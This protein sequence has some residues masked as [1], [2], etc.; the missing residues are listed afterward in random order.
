MPPAETRPQIACIALGSNLGDRRAAIRAAVA[1]I[2][3][4]HGTSI[5]A[6]SAPVETAPVGPPGQR[7]YLNAAASIET[8]LSPRDLLDALLRIEHDLGR[9]RR[10]RWGPRTIDLDLILFGDRVTDE[11]GLTLP[12]PRF[13][14][15]LFVLEPLAEIEPGLT[16]PVTGRSV[17]ELLDDRLLLC[18][19]AEP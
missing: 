13:R 17:L 12:H 19:G 1:A 14:E 18:R 8:T 7:D 3:E 9:V 15:R 10:E 5:R 16:D 11:P 4:L 6:V 2:A